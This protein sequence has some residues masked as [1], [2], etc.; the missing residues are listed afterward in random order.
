MD[1]DLKRVLASAPRKREPEEPTPL[2]TPW[3]EALDPE[4]V[5]QEHPNPQFAREN[6][7]MLNGWWDYAIVPCGKSGSG[8]ASPEASNE[9]PSETLPE[10]DARGTSTC[11]IDACGI[12][13]AHA[14]RSA[15][16][17]SQFDGRIL[18]PFSP[19]AL[20]SGVGRQLQPDEL[21]W[22]KRTF[23]LDDVPACHRFIL[24]FEAVDYACACY[25]NGQVAGEHVGGYLPFSFDITDL[26]NDHDAEKEDGD[27]NKDGDE[28]KGRDNTAE[29]NT[30]KGNTAKGNIAENGA[31]ENGRAIELALCVYD[32]SDTGVQLRGKQKLEA[33][34][35][36]Y[37]AQSGIWQ[38]VWLEIVPENHLESIRLDACPE[39]ESL[40]ITAFMQN[41]SSSTG[42]AP[43]SNDPAA[44]SD[45][46]AA[47]GPTAASETTLA[48]NATATSDPVATNETAAARAIT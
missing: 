5:L 14:W 11:G 34:G 33:S 37:T 32:P 9:A 29:S 21:L 25:V 17:P 2:L 26:M 27:E 1:L 13:T 20:L 23:S 15:T 22:Y 8:E 48:S 12:S 45:A 6:V 3:G 46:A 42:E 44:T 31:G 43:L 19:E 30:A 35:I 36:W 4:H 39:T 38:S 28:S 47:N 16:P 40:T 18:V 10:A 7:R 41:T 24:H